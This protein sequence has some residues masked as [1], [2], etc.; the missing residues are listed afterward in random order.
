[1]IKMGNAN[2]VKELAY[3]ANKMLRI[4]ISVKVG[5]IYKIGN[6]YYVKAKLNIVKNAKK[7]ASALYVI[8][9]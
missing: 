3:I 4:V 8:M 5:L 6:A 9:N 7:E 2:F 1:M